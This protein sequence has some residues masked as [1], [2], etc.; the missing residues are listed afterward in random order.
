M[1]M[2]AQDSIFLNRCPIHSILLKAKAESVLFW[3]TLKCITQKWKLNKFNFSPMLKM[4][5]RDQ[6]D[7]HFKMILLAYFFSV[8][9]LDLPTPVS[10]NPSWGMHPCS[11]PTHKN[12]K[13]ICK[14]K[15]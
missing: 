4:F 15:K 13:N 14:Y 9:E 7:G 12:T 2:A 10:H 1:S 8:V 6:R 3:P 5:A 11:I